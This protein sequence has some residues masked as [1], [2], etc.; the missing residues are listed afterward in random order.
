MRSSWL[1]FAT[2]SLRQARP[3]LDLA[4]VAATARSAM[5]VSSGLAG[6]VAHDAGIAGLLRHLNGLQ[7]LGQAADLVHLDED[8]V[9]TAHLDALGQAFGIRDEQGRRPPAARGRRCGR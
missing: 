7:R 6:T 8:G 3:G 1:Y 2:R 9:R 5:V 4:G